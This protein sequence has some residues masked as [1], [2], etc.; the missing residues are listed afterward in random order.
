MNGVGRFRTQEV[1][2]IFLFSTIMARSLGKNAFIGLCFWSNIQWI[3]TS[4]QNML[5]ICFI[6]WFIH[7]YEQSFHVSAS[8]WELL[9]LKFGLISN[10]RFHL[11]KLIAWFKLFHQGSLSFQS[12]SPSSHNFFFVI[13]MKLHVLNKHTKIFAE[14]IYL[15]KTN[16]NVSLLRF[17]HV[18]NA[19]Y[20][21]YFSN[22][23]CSK[24]VKFKCVALIY[25]SRTNATHSIHNY[26]R[27]ETYV[28][29]WIEFKW[30]KKWKDKTAIC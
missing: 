3:V 21:F 4:F 28:C 8:T 18:S 16:R 6:V 2:T 23:I 10:L 26:N 13:I 5:D 1:L 7:I 20:S 9:L 29:P 11:K 19:Y 22:I 25:D 15:Y 24:F 12:L 27:K 30:A 17:D 14:E